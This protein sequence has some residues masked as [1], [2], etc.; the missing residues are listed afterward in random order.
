MVE[1]NFEFDLTSTAKLLSRYL[2]REIT[3][4]QPRGQAVESITGTL[5][6]TPGGL[7]LRLP[8]GSVRIVSANAPVKLQ[9]PGRPHQQA[10]AGLGHRRLA[11]RPR[12]RRASPTRPAA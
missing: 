11:R 3:V 2:E 9:P 10:H 12:S 7:T 4:E 1:Q 8:D 5:V 6:G